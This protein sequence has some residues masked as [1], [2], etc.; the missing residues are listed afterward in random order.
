MLV[1]QKLNLMIK[2]SNGNKTTKATNLLN[3]NIMSMHMASARNNLF[4]LL[5]F[6]ENFVVLSFSYFQ[7]SCVVIEIKP[8]RKFHVL[9]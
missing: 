1:M 7:T 9:Q 4:F 8:R 2:I 3:Q 5:S 6:V